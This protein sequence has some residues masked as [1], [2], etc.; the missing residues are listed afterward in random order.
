MLFFVCAMVIPTCNDCNTTCVIDV[1]DGKSPEY[2]PIALHV[3]QLTS[4]NKDLLL[5]VT[6]A[7][8]VSSFCRNFTALYGTCGSRD[9][10]NFFIGIKRCMQRMGSLGNCL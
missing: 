7:F 1:Y 2:F 6:A 10:A 8:L 3:Y 9:V 5:S 4:I